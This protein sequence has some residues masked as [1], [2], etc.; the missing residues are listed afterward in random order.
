MSVSM[1][2]KT[3]ALGAL[4]LAATTASAQVTTGS[5]CSWN[6]ILGAANPSCA[7]WSVTRTYN[8]TFSLFNVSLT[9][10]SAPSVGG[11]FTTVFAYVP[12][13]VT[14]SAVS[15]FTSSIPSWSLAGGP[16]S[17][18]VFQQG[19]LLGNSQSIIDWAT[20]GRSNAI[21]IGET[22][23][24]TFQIAGD[25]EL[26]QLGVHAQGVGAN[27]ESQWITFPPSTVVPE[28][29]TYALM[30]TGLLG[31]GAAARRRRAK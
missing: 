19:V 31:L 1:L 21:E 12:T 14:E 2:R 27:S 25:V 20:S 7:S 8:G 28:P 24:F 10:T 17:G 9:N 26:G 6:S 30:A 5:G 29:S 13:T 16:F 4:A 18:G 22:G 3:L 23:V 15:G 11:F